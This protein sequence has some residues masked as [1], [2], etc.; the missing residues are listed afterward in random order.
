MGWK[1]REW[2]AQQ[3]TTHPIDTIV[4]IAI[5]DRHNAKRGGCWPHV[6]TIAAEAHCSERTVRYALK[7]LEAAGLIERVTQMHAKRGQQANLYR[8]VKNPNER[9]SANLTVPLQ[10]PPADFAGPYKKNPSKGEPKGPS[11]G[12]HLPIKVE[13]TREATAT[14][15]VTLGTAA[16]FGT[17]ARFLARPTA[18]IQGGRRH[19]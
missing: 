17:L 16:G 10:A 15:A 9:S 5:A 7:R 13:D 3:R 18:R 2:A 6:K 12:R 1:D 4:L 11:Q 8:L 14:V 19:G